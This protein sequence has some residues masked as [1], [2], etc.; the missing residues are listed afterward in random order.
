MA[1]T[2]GSEQKKQLRAVLA[3]QEGLLL[4]KAREGLELS[5]NRDRDGT[6]DSIDESNE[7]ELLS[8]E[9]RL[10]DREKMLLTK[11]RAAMQR[12]DEG[13]VNDCEDC[14]GPIGFKRLLVRP[15]TT[16]CI[17]CKELRE[18]QEAASEGPNGRRSGSGLPVLEDFGAE[19]LELE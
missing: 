14:D 9:L 13:S 1:N 5:M 10:R 19:L 16:L 17:A 8:T 12:L 4:T 15:V 18:A 3:R 2:L 7:E 11:I 6:G